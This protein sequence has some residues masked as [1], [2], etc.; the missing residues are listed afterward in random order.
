MPSLWHDSANDLFKENPEL[1]GK[2]LR[3]LMGVEL[4]PDVPLSLAPSNFIDRPSRDLI[5]DTVIVAGPTGEPMRGIIVEVQQ[6][7]KA[8]KRRQWPRYAAALWL[9]HDCPVDVLVI[10]PDEPTAAWF[11]A[12]IPTK[13]EG[14]THWPKVLRPAQVPATT[15]AE[16]V[17]ADPLMAVLSVAYYG[18]DRAVADAFVAGIG[19]LGA[20]RGQDYYECG[21]RM[22]PAAVRQIL[23]ELVST[24][25]KEPYSQFGKR[26]YGE[27]RVEGLIEGER[28]TVLMVLKARN[29]KV[30]ESER[31]R[32]ANCADLDQLKAWAEAALTATNTSDVFR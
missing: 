2:I 5:A 3:D 11:A 27:G 10:C 16:Q 19:S 21:V 1:A 30:T 6:N 15:T 9:Q 22:S 13:L 28:N 4:P 25:Y 14:Y 32:V 20:E 12:A 26:H 31:E 8:D 18:T 24:T 29:L 7:K 23:E 17:A